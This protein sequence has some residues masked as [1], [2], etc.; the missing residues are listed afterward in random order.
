MKRRATSGSS[1]YRRFHAVSGSALLPN[2]ED[3]VSV[4]A[5]VAGAPV[6][7]ESIQLIKTD[8]DK[9]GEYRIFAV[10]L[11]EGV[12]GRLGMV[13]SGGNSGGRGGRGW[14]DLGQDGC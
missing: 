9:H 2:L 5:R 3:G 8:G 14:M 4:W 6:A 11:S 12:V 7:V 13:Q 1:A 10:L